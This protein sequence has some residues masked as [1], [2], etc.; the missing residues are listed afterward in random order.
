MNSTFR[1]S[2]ILV[3]GL[4]ALSGCNEQATGEAVVRTEI[5]GSETGSGSEQG[6]V[7]S[8]QRAAVET[9][10]RPVIFENEPFIHC[11]AVPARH[12][13]STALQSSDGT[14]YRGLAQYAAS[15]S[16]DAPPV[17]FAVNGG[18]YDDAGDPIGYYVENSERLKELNRNAGEGNFHMLPNG[19]FYGS[20]GKWEI[21]TSDDF[22][23]S[24][25]DRPEFGTQSGPM[26][27]INGKLHPDIATDGTSKAIRNAV[28][29]DTR[30]RAH[31]VISNRA[32]SFGK[33]ARLYRDE[34]DVPNALY[35]D[36]NVSALWNPA[37]DRLDTGA[38][39]GPIIVVEKR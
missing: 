9:P 10:C 8:E 27:V 29:I 31:F 32:V 23:S 12:H 16:S 30:G 24:V 34:L 38:A 17:A 39:I 5:G 33:M 20:D 11:V 21:R 7:A 22:F 3:L 28:G 1:K 6:N 15:R 2:L 4:T 36:G 13:I 37:A 14:P 25:S 19:V 35:L 26:L 18:M